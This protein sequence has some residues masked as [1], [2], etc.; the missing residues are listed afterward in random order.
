[1]SKIF[2]KKKN[3]KSNLLDLSNTDKILNKGDDIHYYVKE[4]LPSQKEWYNSVYTYN[5][6]YVKNIAP[7]DKI[8]CELIKSFFNLH[9]VK[10]RNTEKFNI[11]RKRI[12]SIRRSINRILLSKTEILHTNKKAFFNIFIYNGEKRYLVNKLKKINELSKF[13]TNNH[14]GIKIK[15]IKQKA[16]KF[17]FLTKKI[18]KKPTNTIKL[19]IKK[20]PIYKYPLKKSLDIYCFILK[21]FIKKSLKK[22]WLNNHYKY[23]LWINKSKFENTYIYPLYKLISKYYDKKIEF[24][25]INIKYLH[26]NSSILS[27]IIAIKIR[28]RKNTV[29]KVLNK[30]FSSLKLPLMVRNYKYLFKNP[31]YWLANIKENLSSIDLTSINYKYL[32]AFFSFS[33]KKIF[34][35]KNFLKKNQKHDILDQLIEKKVSIENENRKYIV[36]RILNTINH[37][38]VYGVRLDLSGRL[39]KRFIAARSITKKKYKGTIRNI[40][41]CYKGFSSVIIRGHLYSNIQY[42]KVSSKRRIG[43]FGVKGWINNL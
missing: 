13:T 32:Y 40:D 18:L 7:Y 28:N 6:N 17:L 12:I 26:L 23:L 19:K 1:M 35:K 15:I 20:K 24:N 31:N 9:Y 41:S 27:Q 43:S 42:S 34:L 36:N 22:E 5:K 33:K 3:S 39:T 16:S 11:R 37:K 14:I 21:I 30:Y 2:L 8:V 29:I 10:N 25:I 4:K 38:W